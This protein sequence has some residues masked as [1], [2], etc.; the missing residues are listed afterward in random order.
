[1]TVIWNSSSLSFSTLVNCKGKVNLLSALVV[2]ILM[3]SIT[4]MPYIAI[5]FIIPL[6]RFI[7]AVILLGC[8]E[9]MRCRLLLPMCAVSVAQSVCYGS[10]TGSASLCGG[11]SV[12][13]LP[14]YF[15]FL[16]WRLYRTLL[17]SVN[18]RFNCCCVQTVICCIFG[19]SS[20]QYIYSAVLEAV[21]SWYI[22]WS[23]DAGY[24]FISSYMLCL[25]D[26][27]LWCWIV[28]QS[29]VFKN[30]ICIDYCAHMKL[31]NLFF[32]LL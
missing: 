7:S 28:H 1:M 14:N 21:A 10:S 17:I 6:I 5:L 11:H 26:F 30:N 12:Q 32:I 8:I 13:P 20:S 16:F 15:G 3:S 27:S 29:T 24:I 22:R 9:C 18:E 2:V 19:F 31:M 4:V 23:N 25:R